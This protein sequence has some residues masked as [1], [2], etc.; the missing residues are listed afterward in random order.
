MFFAVF[1]GHVCQNKTLSDSYAKDVIR[2]R[3]SA[4]KCLNLDSLINNMELPKN[5]EN[6]ARTV[7][8]AI[9]LALGVSPGQFRPD[10]KLSELLVI[11]CNDGKTKQIMFAYDVYYSLDKLVDDK[12]CADYLNNNNIPKNEELMIDYLFS[13]ELTELVEIIAGLMK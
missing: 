9:A 2:S 8:K 10:D 7:V 6:N 11:D 12:K 5:I 4:R 13:K 1:I 3:L